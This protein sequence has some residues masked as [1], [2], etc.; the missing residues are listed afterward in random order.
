M[1]SIHSTT[2]ERNFHHLSPIQRGQ[3]YQLCKEK[4]LTQAQIA[5][6]A[7]VHQSTISR[8]LRRGEVQQMNTDRV[9]F[10]TYAPDFSALQYKKN[11]KKC[12][13]SPGIAKYDLEFF[14]ELSYEIKK[15]PKERI[16]SIAPF[17]LTK[18]NTLIK[19]SRVQE[20]C[21]R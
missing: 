16:Y 1:A 21:I 20:P 11:R 6:E 19:K 12:R 15:K 14:K 17:A 13:I 10:T 7:G 3:I 8:E 4:R 2:K 9:Y 5:K 18:R